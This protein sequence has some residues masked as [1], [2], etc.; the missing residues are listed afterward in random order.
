MAQA[1]PHQ[2][3]NDRRD[4][5]R[6]FRWGAIAFAVLLAGALGYNMLSHDRAGELNPQAPTATQQQATPAPADGG[7]SGAAGPGTAGGRSTGDTSGT[8]APR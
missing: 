8:G 1:T 7:T 6:A 3:H 5:K 2:A 4:N